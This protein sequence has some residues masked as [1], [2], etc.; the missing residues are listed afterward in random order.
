M[1]QPLS[2]RALRWFRTAH[3]WTGLVLGLA[4][5]AEAVTGFWLTH[6]KRFE[7]LGK[8]AFAAPSLSSAR[9]TRLVADGT[10]VIAATKYSLLR[11]QDGGKT[12][13][14]LPI[15]LPLEITAVALRGD[16]LLVGTENG[17]WRC[18]LA[19]ATCR[20]GGLGLPTPAEVKD[21]L[22]DAERAWVG[23]HHQG[24]FRAEGEGWVP[25]GDGLEAA[26]ELKDGQRQLHVHALARW[27][28]RLMVG[29]SQGVFELQPQGSQLVGL[30]G[31]SVETLTAESGALFA[32]V[33]GA[34]RG[35]QPE[36]RFDGIWAQ[37]EPRGLKLE[38]GASSL[39]ARRDVLERNGEAIALPQVSEG[40]LTVGKLMRELHTGKLFGERL[41]L[42]YDLI[43]LSLVM[44]VSTG[45]FLYAWP[46]VLRRRKKIAAA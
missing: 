28:E 6:Q 13:V 27:N 5:L 23:L 21:I 30:E 31:Q 11:S 40:S 41:W 10:T 20:E 12:F 43:A 37:V 15:T 2:T 36:W 29:T 19:T 14:L 9:I 45:F 35:E 42:I 4:I 32:A 7:P 25:D 24:V 33:K 39:V 34:G 8:I 16:L 18:R 17:L 44:F 1:S 26:T 38:V 46:A 3:A 22:M